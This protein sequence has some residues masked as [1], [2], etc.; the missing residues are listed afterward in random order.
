MRQ[1]N[2]L[3]NER[4]S[5]SPRNIAPAW[6]FFPKFGARNGFEG[7]RDNSAKRPAQN[8]WAVSVTEHKA[9][10]PANSGYL[11]VF[12]NARKTQ[13]CVVEQSTEVVEGYTG[14]CDEDVARRGLDWMRNEERVKGRIP[15]F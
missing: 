5:A 10:K 2:G 15:L 3:A 6:S 11:P 14:R 1:S 12:R 8:N 13:D 4:C 7:A 9:Q